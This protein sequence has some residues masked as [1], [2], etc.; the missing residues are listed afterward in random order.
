MRFESNGSS[1][2]TKANFNKQKNVILIMITVIFYLC[3]SGFILYQYSLTQRTVQVVASKGVIYKNQA[4][5]LNNIQPYEMTLKEW[6][7]YSLKKDQATDTLVNKIVLWKDRKNLQGK[8]AGITKTDGQFIQYNE[9]LATYQDYTN[10][11]RF[12]YPGKVIVPLD[13]SNSNVNVFKK[14]LNVGDKI[15]I[16]CTYEAEYNTNVS[17]QSYVSNRKSTF[18]VS[19]VVVKDLFPGVMICDIL[20][21]KGES[22]LDYTTYVNSLP[23]AQR[24]ELINTDEYEKSTK[25]SSLLLALTPQEL[26]EYEDYRNR[27]GIKFFISLPE[28]DE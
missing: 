6:Q 3:L 9:V 14:I 25:V 27:T 24:V 28:G 8:Y 11:M 22:L 23:E 12:S 10:L 17:I 4:F 20:N 5:T 13:I 21:S 2:F 18:E 19:N 16:S 15:N 1:I 7:R 26:A